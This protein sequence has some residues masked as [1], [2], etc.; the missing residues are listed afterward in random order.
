MS[1]GNERAGREPA[2]AGPARRP[3][4]TSPAALAAHLGRELSAAA[5]DGNGWTDLYYAAALDWAALA[6]ALLAVGAPVDARRRTDGE[7]LGPRLLSTLSMCGQDRLHQVRRVSATPLHIGAAADAREVVAV[8]LEGG[9]DP[10]L[11]RRPRRRRCTTRWRATA[12]VLGARGAAGGAA[13]SKASRRCTRRRG[14]TRS[15]WWRRCWITGPMSGLGTA[16]AIPR[17]IG[18]RRTT[19]RWRRP[20]F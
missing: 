12:A 6:R 3:S 13:T 14:G 7:A 20:S 5:V 9:A 4:I 2:P 15:R 11:P 16:G 18:P 19:R 1:N 8:L 10:T 17:C